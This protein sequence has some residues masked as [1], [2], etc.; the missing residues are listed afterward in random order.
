MEKGLILSLGSINKDIQ[1]RADRWPEPGE[2]LEVKDLLTLGGGKAANRAYL[3]GRLGAPTLLLGRLGQDPEADEVLQ[4]LQQWGVNL[5]QVRRLPG[6]R[7]GLA[8]VVVRP[9]GDK[10]ILEAPN[11]NQHWEPEG[12]DRV[13]QVI[14]GAPENSILTLDLEVPGPVVRRALEAAREKKLRVLLDPSPADRLDDACYQLADLLTPNTSEAAR[15]VGFPVESPEDGFRACRKILERGARQALVKLGSQGY[16]MILEGR[17]KHLPAPPAKVV[18]TTG[19]GDAFIS[20]LAFALWEGQPL[21]EA[22]GFGAAASSLAVAGYGAQSSY[23]DR[24]AIEAK[25]REAEASKAV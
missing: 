7:T 11:A 16:V 25:I 5:E 2:T 21:E 1:V 18:D 3:S 6:Q 15:M 8:L 12:P 22:I 14:A 24:A 23:P 10:T 20:A 9:D 17:E 13:A 4:G 19:G